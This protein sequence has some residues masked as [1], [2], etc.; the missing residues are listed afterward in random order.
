LSLLESKASTEAKA[1]N[2]KN[3]AAETI[4]V[5]PVEEPHVRD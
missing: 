5:P 3:G 2:G 4:A 1:A